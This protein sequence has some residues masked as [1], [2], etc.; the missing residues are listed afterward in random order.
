MPT[1][2]LVFLKFLALVVALNIIRYVAGLPLEK[3]L[4]F[5]R[6][7]GAMERSASCF[8]IEFTTFDW[9]TSTFYNFMMWLTCVW[10]FVK[11]RRELGGHEVVRSLK[12]FGLMYLMFT[13]VSAIYMNHYLPPHYFY[14][15]NMLDGLVVFPLVAVANG[16]LYP[17]LFRKPAGAPD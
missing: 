16:L 2:L 17:L 5:D 9:V 7:F 10:V 15:Y 11:M 1:R 12:V 4:I 6:L 13:S 3:F 14:F 8:N